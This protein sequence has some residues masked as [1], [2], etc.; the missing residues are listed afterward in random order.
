[1]H[2]GTTGPAKARRSGRGRSYWGLPGAILVLAVLFSATGAIAQTGKAIRVVVPYAAGGPAD[3]I[4]RILS[5]ALQQKMD[6]T[7]FIENKPG[8]NTNIGTAYVAKSASDGDTLLVTSTSFT[9]NPSIYKNIPYDPVKDFTPIST[10]ASSPNVFVASVGSG[11]RSIKDIVARERGKPGSLEFG[12]A[13]IGTP[14]HLDAELLNNLEGIKMVHIPFSGG[15]PAVQAL[16]GNQI[17]LGSLA[18]NN[19]RTFIEDGTI[20]GVGIMSEKRWPT[21]PNVPTMNELGYPNFVSE[22]TIM[23]LGPAGM[24]SDVTSALSRATAQA[25]AE[26]EV[27]DR[28]NSLGFRPIAGDPEELRARIARELV[29]YGEIARKAKVSM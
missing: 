14:T 5:S 6:R 4:A 19:V 22:T 9:I 26:P 27:R 15:A 24:S 23:F 16:L 2:R 21:L 1:M 13:G 18:L 17:Q 12:T 10:V 25:L 3:T 28:I 29:S 7:F 11:I 20:V 8:A